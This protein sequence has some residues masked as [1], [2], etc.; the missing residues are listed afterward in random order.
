MLY[1]ASKFNQKFIYLVLIITLI[2]NTFFTSCKNA[3]NTPFELSPAQ[4][5][6]LVQSG[7]KT[8]GRVFILKNETPNKV[9]YTFQTADGKNISQKLEISS[10]KNALLS[11]GFPLSDRDEFEVSYLADDPQINQIN[12]EQPTQLQIQNYLRLAAAVEVAKHPDKKPAECMCKVFN[13]EQQRGWQS[14]A[15]I[16]HQGEKSADNAVFNE[17]TYQKLYEEDVKLVDY[18]MQRCKPR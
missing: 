17:L 3:P 15:N 9:F 10:D 13:T 12:Y 4:K 18:I 11:N 1:F 16:Y 5:N 8:T 2:L 6:L 7:I 14:T